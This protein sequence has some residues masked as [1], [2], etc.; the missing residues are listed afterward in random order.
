V[1]RPDAAA[2]AVGRVIRLPTT[3]AV[4]GVAA[5]AGYLSY[6][7]AYAVVHAIASQA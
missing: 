6:Q 3:V 5:I 7:H 4:V 1:S 2:G